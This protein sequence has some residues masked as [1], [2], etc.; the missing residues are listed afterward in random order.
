MVLQLLNARGV[1]DELRRSADRGRQLLR[2][3]E[4]PIVA[5]LNGRQPL[6]TLEAVRALAEQ[7]AARAA[8]AKSARPAQSAA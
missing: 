7:R 4:L 2:S 3:G 1:G 8:A 5:L 6:T